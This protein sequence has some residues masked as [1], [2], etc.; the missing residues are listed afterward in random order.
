MFSSHK[1]SKSILDIASTIMKEEREYV[2]IHKPSGKVAFVGKTQQERDGY[3][4]KFGSISHEPAQTSAGHKKVGDT[5][6][7][8]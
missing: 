7:R 3:I 6:M 8:D 2:A 1:I 4:S 5:W